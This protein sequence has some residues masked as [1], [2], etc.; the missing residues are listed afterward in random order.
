MA[1]I[2]FNIEK[3][4]KKYI[5]IVSLIIFLILIS[6]SIALIMFD[7][8][9]KISNNG[10][11]ADLTLD[12]ENMEVHVAILPN[13]GYNKYIVSNNLEKITNTSG[14]LFY[15]DSKELV[16]MMPNN[17]PNILHPTKTVLKY[18]LNGDAKQVVV[19]LNP[20]NIIQ[21]YYLVIETFGLGHN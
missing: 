1:K 21:L 12:N 8:K 9:P 6:L 2:N 14:I 11:L 4:P 20:I 5:I 19:T 13:K 17:Y 16:M 10:T 15:R 3:I 18:K 7:A